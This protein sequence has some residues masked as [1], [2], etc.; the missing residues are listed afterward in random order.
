MIAGAESVGRFDAELWRAELM[1]VAAARAAASGALGLREALEALLR[2]QPET[3]GMEVR[4]TGGLA[5]ASQLCPPARL[6]LLRIAQSIA[7]KPWAT[8]KVRG[9]VRTQ[10]HAVRQGGP[11]FGR[12]GLRRSPA[13]PRQP[14]AS[15]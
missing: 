3:T 5:E 7:G 1:G 13:P 11:P 6:L 12:K 9:K 8:R 15:L 10:S 14:E 4:A 2:V